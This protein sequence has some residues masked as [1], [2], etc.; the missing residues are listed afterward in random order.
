MKNDEVTKSVIWEY[1]M[2]HGSCEGDG[3][4]ATRRIIAVGGVRLMN[5]EEE[6]RNEEK[7]SQEQI[8]FAIFAE[9]CVSHFNK[10]TVRIH[11]QCLWYAW[12]RHNTEADSHPTL[13]EVVLDRLASRL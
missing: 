3:N 1:L 5:Q 2:G 10:A 13:I 11:G 7:F 12:C 8:E 4:V 9:I 6:G